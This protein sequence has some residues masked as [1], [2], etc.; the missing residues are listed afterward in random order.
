MSSLVENTDLT[1]IAAGKVDTVRAD[2]AEKGDEYAKQQ[3][4]E[5][6]GQTKKLIAD[7]MKNLT[8]S[9]ENEQ[10]VLGSL[11]SKDE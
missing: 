8:L 3:I 1:A 9:F 6:G 4:V 10:E 7:N 11:K 5:F 2:C